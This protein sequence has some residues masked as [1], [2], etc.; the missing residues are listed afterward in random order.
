MALRNA[1]GS[2]G[3]G[4]RRQFGGS[5]PGELRSVFLDV[6]ASQSFL[7]RARVFLVVCGS[8]WVFPEAIWVLWPTLKLR[9]IARPLSVSNR[10][11]GR[12]R[13]PCRYGSVRQVEML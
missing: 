3:R 10:K 2:R 8:F 13:F 9:A 4:V 11:S 12:T 6:W 5:G 7:G 1:Q